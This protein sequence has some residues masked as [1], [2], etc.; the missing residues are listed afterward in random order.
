MIDLILCGP[1][2]LFCKWD[3]W[4]SWT[5][6]H[7]GIWREKYGC[8]QEES[9]IS[10]PRFSQTLPGKPHMTSQYMMIPQPRIRNMA[11]SV[12]PLEINLGLVGQAMA[13]D[14][15][16][17]HFLLSRDEVR[18]ETLEPPT[19]TKLIT[20]PLTVIRHHFYQRKLSYLV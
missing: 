5:A 13:L 12:A 4:E 1:Q 15:G 7:R 20:E 2:Q 19:T 6:K 8:K 10:L 17:G 3:I 18:A 14:A 11:A 9:C 16:C